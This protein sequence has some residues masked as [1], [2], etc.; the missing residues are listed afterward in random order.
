M[1]SNNTLIDAE[2]GV[3]ISNLPSEENSGRPTSTTPKPT[4]AAARPAAVGRDTEE[5]GTL[6]PVKRNGSLECLPGKQQLSC[7]K[8]ESLIKKK[9]ACEKKHTRES[10]AEALPAGVLFNIFQQSLGIERNDFWEQCDQNFKITS[11]AAQVPNI[12]VV[13]LLDASPLHQGSQA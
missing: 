1:I 10:A 7:Q 4:A 5:P 12:Q 3:N 9:L 13:C 8:I 6:L 2:T 11:F